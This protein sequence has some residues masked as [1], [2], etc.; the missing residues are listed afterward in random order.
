MPLRNSVVSQKYGVSRFD[1]PGTS[2]PATVEAP[3][4]DADA[5]AQERV[6]V[7]LGPRNEVK[8]V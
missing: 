7:D 3:T 2:T 4:W 1:T 5:Q 6:W 8:G